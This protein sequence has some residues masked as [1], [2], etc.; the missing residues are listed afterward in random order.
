MDENLIRLQYAFSRLY[1]IYEEQSRMAKLIGLNVGNISWGN[2]PVVVWSIIIDQARNAGQL[3]NLVDIGLEEN[4]GTAEFLAY[5]N[6]TQSV[7]MPPA[8]SRTVVADDKKVFEKL[9]GKQSTLLPIAF[10]EKGLNMAASVCLVNVGT[11]GEVGTGFLIDGNILITNNHVLKTPEIAAASTC[12]FNYQDNLSGNERKVVEFK[13]APDDFF[14]TSQEF[15]FT[16]VKVKDNEFGTANEQFGALELKNTVVKKDEF[17]NIIQHPAGQK[18]QIAL[19]HNIV[20]LAESGIVQ[21]LT[22]TLPGA[23]GS[24][25]FN[26]DWEIVALHHAGKYIQSPELNGPKAYNEGININRIIEALK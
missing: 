12:W 17:V 2:K 26:S 7:S 4:P 1:P 9:T 5:K 15:D 21:Y 18:K 13:L 3:D 23:S 16:A 24:P 8:E 11:T 19:Y 14:K 20:T 10:L 22:D 6:N 25:V